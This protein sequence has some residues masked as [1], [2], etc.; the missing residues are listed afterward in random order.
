[1]NEIPD[2][3]YRVAKVSY[4]D[5][6]IAAERTSFASLGAQMLALRAVVEAVAPHIARAAS[7]RE[8]KWARSHVELNYFLP[9]D[10]EYSDYEQ[11]MNGA[12]HGI[13]T[14]LSA[15]IDELEDTDATE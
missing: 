8:L 15:R 3:V 6:F 1:M 12:A 7:L 11:G 13:W 2:E 9:P 4:I 5:A 10:G 14:D